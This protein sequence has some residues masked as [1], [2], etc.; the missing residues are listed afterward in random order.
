MQEKT[1][2]IKKK[3]LAHS[4][5]PIIEAIFAE[6]Y[7]FKTQEDAENKLHDIETSFVKSKH[8]SEQYPDKVIIWIRGYALTNEERDAGCL[9]NF[10][11]IHIKPIKNKR[12]TLAAIKII[13][14]ADKHPVRKR[15]SA[16]HPDGGYWLMRQ[17]KKNWRY[18]SIE[19]AYADLIKMAEDFPEISIPARNKLYTI[20]YQKNTDN[21]LP[22]QKVVLE[23]EAADNG[24]FIITC[25]ENTYN[26]DEK[27]KQHSSTHAQPTQSQGHFTSMIQLKRKM[28]SN[29]TNQDT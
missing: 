16:K 20:L 15:K 24:K 10:A 25:K 26:R 8:I 21:L 17:I 2:H 27:K 4:N 28:L 3:A 11:L 12:F 5:S 29:I 14:P 23:V 9:G 6:L 7:R 19:T 13:A 18:D 1:P 22:L